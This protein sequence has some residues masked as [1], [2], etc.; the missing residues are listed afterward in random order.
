MVH[1]DNQGRTTINGAHGHPQEDLGVNVSY[2]KVE[3]TD[4]FPG[5]V[6]GSTVCLGRVLKDGEFSR[7][8]I[9]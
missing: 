1:M 6:E 2:P 4:P 7:V 8:G 9:R 3:T 5:K